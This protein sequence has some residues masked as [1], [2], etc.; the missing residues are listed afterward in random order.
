MNNKYKVTVIDSLSEWEKIAREWDEVLC[1]SSS[2]SVFLTWEW[3]YTWAECFPEEKRRL[4]I[5]LVHMGDELVGI[6]PWCIRHTQSR[7][8]PL[9]QIEFLGKLGASSDYLDVFSKKGRER[10]VAI[11]IYQFLLG[12]VSSAWDSLMLE[13]VP[14]NSL[15]LLHFTE[16]I[17]EDGKYAEMTRGGFCP[18]VSLPESKDDFMATLSQHRRGQ[19]RRDQKILQ[20]PHNVTHQSF[21]GK[22]IE[23]ILDDFVSFFSDKKG[24]TN[25]SFFSFIKRFALKSVENRWVQIDMLTSNASKIACFYQ[26]RYQGTVFGY[27][28]A[29]D[30]SFNSK[31]SVGNLLLGLC[32]ENSISEKMSVYDFLKGTEAHKFHWTNGGRSSLNL[33]FCQR[34]IP[35]LLT[36]MGKFLKY[37]A[38]CI[39]K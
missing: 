17:E 2:N 13:D 5:L 6:A 29:T 28:M 36:V 32:L 38:K 30:K 14:S 11:E 4:F 8:I 1:Q 9:K 21:T 7:F 18:Y 39:L 33:F 12:N 37:L 10:E 19:Y 22:Q 34:N 20:S 27:L 25:E 23:P 31:V 26:L 35:A 3:L 15:F 24:Y 16:K